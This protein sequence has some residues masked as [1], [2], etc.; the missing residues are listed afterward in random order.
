MILNVSTVTDDTPGEALLTSLA[1]TGNRSRPQRPIFD[2]EKNR[3]PERSGT[4]MNLIINDD[5]LP[6]F[7]AHTT[8]S[9][10]TCTITLSGE[11]DVATTEVLRRT[12][13]A[14]AADGAQRAVVD[15]D[16][17]TFCDASGIRELIALQDRLTGGHRTVT[18]R[19][20]RRRIRGIMKIAGADLV[21]NLEPPRHVH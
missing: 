10:T 16:G 4:A 13:S 18:F 6:T 11:L 5:E 19:A 2:E 15:L 3:S 7:A 20:T 12:L 14:D 9:D 21:L 1:G 17:L 8:T